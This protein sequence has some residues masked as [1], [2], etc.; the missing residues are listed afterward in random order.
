[1]QLVVSTLEV[2]LNHRRSL[3]IDHG[4]VDLILRDDQGSYSRH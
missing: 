2:E 4:R 1:M 3:P